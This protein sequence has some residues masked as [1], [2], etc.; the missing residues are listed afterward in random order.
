MSLPR[1]RVLSGS[2]AGLKNQLR[3]KPSGDTWREMMRRSPFL[4]EV[5]SEIPEKPRERISS[6]P[7]LYPL[8]GSVG[9][10]VEDVDLAAH[11]LSVRVNLL[12]T[13]ALG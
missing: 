3:W 10:R 5:F 7:F 4:L 13:Y 1:S 9:H 2:T 6:I 12:K 11:S 8:G